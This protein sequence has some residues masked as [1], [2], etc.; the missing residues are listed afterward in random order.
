MVVAE[1]TAH[2]PTINPPWPSSRTRLAEVTR[3]RC[4]S[5]R[6]PARV[7]Y[8]ALEQNRR[9]SRRSAALDCAVIMTH[10][11]TRRARVARIA[12]MRWLLAALTASAII[13]LS[14]TS[15]PAA[16]APPGENCGTIVGPPW[17]AAGHRSGRRWDVS[18]SGTSCAAA[19]FAVRRLLREHVDR[20]G[21]LRAIAPFIGCSVDRRHRNIHPYGAAACLGDKVAVSW[22]IA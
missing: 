3:D 2:S 1:V 4:A 14:V 8:R 15:V 20:R 5:S 7:E 11:L 9:V 18:E 10:G 21:R 16:A 22:G 13:G 12:A 17:T 19:V 6:R